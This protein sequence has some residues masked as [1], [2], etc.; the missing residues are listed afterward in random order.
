LQLP[1]IL[2]LLHLSCATAIIIFCAMR[3]GLITV[4]RK[5]ANVLLYMLPQLKY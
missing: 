1:L 4:G 5:Y 3:V 2:A